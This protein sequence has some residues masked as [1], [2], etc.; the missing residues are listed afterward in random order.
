MNKFNS[1]LLA[2]LLAS[3]PLYAQNVAKVNGVTGAKGE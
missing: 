3:G 1:L 2:G